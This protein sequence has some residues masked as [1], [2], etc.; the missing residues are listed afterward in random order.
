MNI[1]YVLVCRFCM[2]V[3]IWG[4]LLIY[5]RF[6]IV[7]GIMGFRIKWKFCVLVVNM[8]KGF[9]IFILIFVL[10]FFL[11]LLVLMFVLLYRFKRSFCFYRL[12]ICSWFY[13]FCKLMNLRNLGVIKIDDWRMVIFLRNWR[14]FRVY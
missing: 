12:I 6:L 4:V 11:C 9:C 7:V 14:L 5:L 8:W 1:I 3:Y 10:F 13:C 2:Y